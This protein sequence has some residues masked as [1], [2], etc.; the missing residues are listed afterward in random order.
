MAFVES[1]YFD[2]ITNVKLAKYYSNIT[3][4]QPDKFALVIGY[5]KKAYRIIQVG[6]SNNNVQQL[7]N[8]NPEKKKQLLMLREE[9]KESIT[10]DLHRNSQIFHQQ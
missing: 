7:F 2:V 8:L 4:N 3:Q 5:Q 1:L 6:F 9:L 10:K